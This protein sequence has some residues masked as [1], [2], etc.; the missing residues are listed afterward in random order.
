MQ[1]KQFKLVRIIKERLETQPTPHLNTLRLRMERLQSQYPDDDF[2]IV[3]CDNKPVKSIDF[4]AADLAHPV[5]KAKRKKA[6]RDAEYHKTMKDK[7]AR[8]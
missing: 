2:Y 5:A 7:L 1:E 6:A 3:D 4:I 8:F